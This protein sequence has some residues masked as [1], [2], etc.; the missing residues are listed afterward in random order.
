[1]NRRLANECVGSRSAHGAAFTLIELLVV[2]A[3]IGI[4]AAMLLPALSKA[5][6]RAISVFCQNNLR[7]LQI[8]WLQYAHDNEDVLV[9]NNYV[10]GMAMGTTNSSSKSEEKMCWFAGYAPL[11]T[12]AVS[13]DNSLL[14]MYNR[15]GA[16][17]HCPADRSTV[18]GVPAMQRNR[19][20]NLSNSANCAAD[21]HFRKY[22]DIKSHASL[23]V[24][25][26]THEDTIWDCTFG[27]I[28]IGDYYQD[29]WL[30]VPANR[31]Q[32]AANLTFADG[33]VEH[34][35]W[36][37]GKSRDLFC[38]HTSSSDDLADLRRLQEHIKGAGGN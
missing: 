36:R 15:S 27:V 33:H 34:W 13:A 37:A 38:M 22:G 28:P 32:Q 20:Y 18:E 1:M 3:I 24:F 14:F 8:C 19:S 35:R 4:L 31:H 25:I 7:Q 12:N 30:D 9:P 29:Y 21:N 17:Y 16:I 6:G 10:T 5:K 2:I 23:F 26:D 11:D